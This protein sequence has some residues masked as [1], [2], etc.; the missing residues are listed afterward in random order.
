MVGSPIF[1]KSQLTN[2]KQRA[3]IK[4]DAAKI[5]RMIS[6]GHFATTPWGCML[7]GELRNGKQAGSSK[8]NLNS[9]DVELCLPGK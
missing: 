6:V 1:Q 8:V 3:V 5:I 4:G 9:S 7:L 2:P